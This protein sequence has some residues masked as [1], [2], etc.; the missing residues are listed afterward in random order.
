MNRKLKKILISNDDGIQAEG[1]QTLT[2][3]LRE[4]G[5]DVYVVAPSEDSS[6]MS[7]G[8]TLKMPLRYK[9]F[10]LDGAFFGYMI[11]GK[12]ADCVKMARWEIYKDIEFDLMISGINRGANLGADLFYSGTFG[13]AAEATLLNIKSI[14]VSLCEPFDE[15]E[16]YDF[17]ANFITKFLQSIDNI[18]FPKN[19]LLNINVPNIEGKK[20][21][22]YKLTNQ[23]DRKYVEN[24]DK[25]YDPHGG[26]YYWI[27]GDAIETFEGYEDD[28]YVI[29]EN[30]ISIT[31]VELNLSAQKFGSY[32]KK[33]LEHEMD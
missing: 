1:I 5:H 21:K 32:L 29:K 17:V 16:N 23:G 14:A 3:K 12:P 19:H 30:Y 15:V 33:E 27:T 13:A 6:G 7:H 18:E 24:F 25:R 20:I 22:G 10:E 4:Y 2:K 28:W 11:N 9:E 8:I 26:E 31:P